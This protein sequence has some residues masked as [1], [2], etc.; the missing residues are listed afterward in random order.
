MYTYCYIFLSLLV[1]KK[2]PSY[3]TI[4]FTVGVWDFWLMCVGFV[5]FHLTITSRKH[6]DASTVVLNFNVAN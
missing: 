3:A 2:V 5:L 4:S 1:Q 6:L